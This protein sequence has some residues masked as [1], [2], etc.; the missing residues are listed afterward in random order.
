M[1]VLFVY[2]N[3]NGFHEDTYSF[4]LASIVS[5]TRV[6]GHIPKVIIVKARK[7]YRKV[8][9]VVSDFKPEVVGF[10]SV[11]SQFNFVKEMALAI[12]KKFNNV[13]TVCGGV[14][15]TIN[16]EC[17]QESEFLD[18]IFIGESESSFIDFLEKLEK[19]ES[20]KNIDNLGYV[21]KDKLIVNNLKPLIHNLEN[22]PYPDREI[23]PYEDTLKVTRYAP[24]LFSRGCPYSCSYCS[25]HAIA[26]AYNLPVNRPRFRSVE[27]SI[28]EIEET[29]GKFFVKKILIVDDIFGLDKEWREEFCEKYR[30][31][32][33]IRFQCLLRANLIDEEL[34]RLL[35]KAGCYRI[36][37]GIESGNEFVRNKIMNRRM[38]NKQIVKAFDAAHKYGIQ[39]N[40]INLI[41]VPGETDEMIWDTIRLNRRVRPTSSGVNIFYPYR[42]TKLG[43][44]CFEKGL[45]D[46]LSYNNFSNERRTTV[47][48]YPEQYKNKLS[49]YR[50]N[51]EIFVYPFSFK[52]HLRRLVRRTFF[53]KYLRLLKQIV[54]SF[55]KV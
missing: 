27:S 55:M 45:V 53:Y 23:Y 1:N 44:Y 48:N 13:V 40:A 31:R 26:K 43:N 3:I 6:K 22:L 41:G 5:I 28:G 16:P 17:I 52:R 47:L 20:Y 35:K 38:S 51:W 19:G 2:P 39:T 33:K 50:E 42:G 46:E 37:I 32:V 14:H 54:Y 11:S 10:S 29:I 34:I 18:G 8:L 24:F 49:Y 36:S 7:E 15:P 30:K 21:E 9:E 4:G 25:N 12:K